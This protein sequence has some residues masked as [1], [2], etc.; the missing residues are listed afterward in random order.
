MIYVSKGMDMV[1]VLATIK[2]T[3][4]I[5]YWQSTDPYICS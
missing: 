3:D 1:A 4:F 5:A 2:E